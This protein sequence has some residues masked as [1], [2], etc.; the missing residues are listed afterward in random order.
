[1]NEARRAVVVRLP[2]PVETHRVEETPDL[3]AGVG[4]V[5]VD[6]KAA[7]VNYPDLLVVSGRYQVTPPLP[8]TPGKEAAGVVR[9]I[10]AGVTRVK[11]GDRVLIHVE[12]GAFATQARAR[13]DQC[14]PLPDR[15][16]FVDAVSLGLAAQTAWFSIVERGGYQ[17]GEAVLVN[18]VT[19]AV[20]LAAAQIAS[21]LGASV[22]AGAGSPDRAR[23]LLEGVPCT[24]IDLGAPD[25][26]NS[27]REQVHAATGGRGADV[28][29]D[30]LGADVF[31]ASLRAM[32]WCGR[33]VTVGFAAGRLPEVK[34]N[35]LLVKNITATG[36]QWSD[37]RD[38]EPGKVARA[39]RMLTVLWER[40]ALKA[41]VMRALPLGDFV[42][43]LRL[44]ETRQATGR[45]VLTMD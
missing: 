7:G 18:G 24:F 21:A 11:T 25:L 30:M 4:E 35:Y 22:L 44:M 17:P 14:M 6:V 8:F 37:Y 12:H 13:E 1:M 28:V 43:A 5:V 19:G 29:I 3:E 26:R 42:E 32:A 15:M 20:G 10:G 38:R 16:G 31:D 40:G 27:L 45:L 36:L 2:G 39:H 41:Q 33:T 34:A 23:A 9:S